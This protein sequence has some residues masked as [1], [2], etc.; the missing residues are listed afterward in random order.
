MTNPDYNMTYLLCMNVCT[1]KYVKIIE[2]TDIRE[3]DVMHLS[4]ATTRILA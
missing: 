4:H 2:L 3:C 1:P